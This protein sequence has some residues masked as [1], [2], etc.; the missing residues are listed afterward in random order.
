MDRFVTIKELTTWRD[1]GDWPDQDFP[2]GVI[3]TLQ[4]AID[5]LE[6]FLEEDNPNEGM[7]TLA[8]NFIKGA[9][10]KEVKS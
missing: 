4:T 2:S 10:G 5:F 8:D 3:D 6:H 1:T 9:R 7:R